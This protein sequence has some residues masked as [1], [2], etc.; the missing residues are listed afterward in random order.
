[1]KRQRSL[2]VS[3]FI[4]AYSCL[5]PVCHPGTAP[6][7]F[8]LWMGWN[9]RFLTNIAVLHAPRQLFLFLLVIPERIG[10]QVIQIPLCR[11]HT[12]H[13]IIAVNRSVMN[14]LVIGIHQPAPFIR[15]QAVTLC[16]VCTLTSG[17]RLDAFQNLLIGHGTSFLLPEE[18][19]QRKRHQSSGLMSSLVI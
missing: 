4:H 12:L 3:L 16:L 11:K 7:V 5:I 14:A 17:Q 2:A 10:D 13:E 19:R 9:K 18:F 15:Q 8:L 6:A 1:M